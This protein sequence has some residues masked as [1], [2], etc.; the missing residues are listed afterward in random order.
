MHACGVSARSNG[1][2]LAGTRV[3]G[4][5]KNVL[6][7]NGRTFGVAAAADVASAVGQVAV[8][9]VRR[10]VKLRIAHQLGAAAVCAME[11][12]SADEACACPR[13]S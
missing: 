12:K 11:S 1:G 3:G 13:E 10:L 9:R 7:V 8:A 4:A 5:P 6:P 2:L